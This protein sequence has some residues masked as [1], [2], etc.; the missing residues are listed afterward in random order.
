[1]ADVRT[2]HERGGYCSGQFT[3]QSERERE[4]ERERA[5]GDE[6]LGIWKVQTRTFV[7]FR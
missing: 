3:R 2:V 5:K 7:P 4:R 6:R 1:M